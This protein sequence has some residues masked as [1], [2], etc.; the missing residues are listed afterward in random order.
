MFSEQGIYNN[1]AQTN[2][3][4]S[5]ID[6]LRSRLADL[7]PSTTGGE[8]NEVVDTGNPAMSIK[9]RAWVRGHWRY[10]NAEFS[11]TTAEQTIASPMLLEIIS[12]H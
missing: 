10:R 3:L 11:F 6:R 4:F 5:Y 9:K 12:L 8:R 2:Y 1:L 7:A